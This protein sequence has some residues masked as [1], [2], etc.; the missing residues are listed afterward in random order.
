MPSC[1]LFLDVGVN[2]RGYHGNSWLA[3]DADWD[4]FISFEHY[5]EV[6]ELAHSGGF[7]AVFLSDHP[8]LRRAA[9]NRP[10]HSLDPIV[11][12]TALAARVPDIGF[13][14]TASSSYNSPYNLARRLAGLDHISG[15]R[16]IWN[17]VSS[18]SPDIAADFGAAP[19]RHCGATNNSTATR[20]R[21][22]CCARSPTGTVCRSIPIPC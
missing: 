15:G 20:T 22:R 19:L 13:V 2:S 12:F 14:I 11:L 9:D 18:F 3:P 7:A 10:L 5:L 1:G 16:V 4:R 6:A 8:A 21:T 17:V